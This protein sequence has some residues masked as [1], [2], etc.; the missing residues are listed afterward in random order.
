M[1]SESHIPSDPEAETLP[2][3][4]LD[5]LQALP[6]EHAVPDAETDAAILADGRAALSSLRPPE[7]TTRRFFWPALSVAACLALA[8]GFLSKLHHPSSEKQSVIRSEDPYALILREVNSLFPHQVRAIQTDGGELQI[9]LA[10]EPVAENAQA[11]VIEACLRGSCT[12][13][14]TYVGQTVVI[15]SRPVTVRT[16]EDGDIVVE[17]ADRQI[18]ELRIKSRR[19]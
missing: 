7:K 1:N 9:A 3:Q 6:S 16:N 10:D 11:V 14:I 2:P 4:W 17:T 18:T 12:T 5:A 13:V 15:E 8:F 19:I